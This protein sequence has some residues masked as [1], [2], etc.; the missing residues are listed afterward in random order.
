METNTSEWKTVEK[1]MDRTASFYLDPETELLYRTRPDQFLS[2]L[3]QYKFIAKLIGPHQEILDLTQAETIG[4]S[5]LKAECGSVSTH[6]AEGEKFDAIILSDV[7]SCVNSLPFLNPNGLMFLKEKQKYFENVRSIF[8][9]IF[10]FSV[11]REVILTGLHPSAESF[12]VVAQ[13]WKL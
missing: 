12:L 2:Q 9:H 13:G 10:F 5:I 11:V 4:R 8:Q 7:N 3:T 1:M 6:A